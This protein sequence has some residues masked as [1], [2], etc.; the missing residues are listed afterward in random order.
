MDPSSDH[1]EYCTGGFD[2]EDIVISGMSGRFPESDSVR[3]LKEGL[4]NKK[5]FVVFTDKRFEKGAYHAPYDSSGL[6]KELDKLDIN[7]FHVAYAHAQQMDPASR[8]HLE[9]TYE[10]IADA[11]ID[12]TDLR[13]ARVGVFNATT[14]E[15]TVKINTSD[16]SFVSLNAI[17][18]MNPNRT[19]HSFDFTGPSYTIDAACSSSA[20]ALWSAV[21]TLRMGQID[22]AVVSGC[23]LNLH[24]CMLAG[25]IGAGIVSTTGNSRPFDAKSDGMIKTEAV[26]AIF[27]QKAKVAR[28]VYAIIP[29][30]RCYSAGYVPEGVNVPSDVMQK[31]IMLDTLNDANVDINDIDFIEAHGTGTQVGDKIELNAI[32][33]VFCKNRSKP[34]LVGAVKSNIGHTEASSGI[35]GVIKSIL[36]FE[37]ESI[38]PNIKFEVPNPN[39]PAL[40]DGKL[41]VVTEP[42]P[43]KKDYI[44]INSLGFG[45][46]L[47]QILLKKNP[48]APGGKK[49][50]SNIP[51]LILFPGTTEEAITTIFE[52]L[53]NTPNLPEEFFALLNKLSFTDPSLKPFRGY[54]LYQGGN[55]PIKEIRVRYSY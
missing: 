2:P 4:Y 31:R 5:D 41:V 19:T 33:E 14:G 46:T 48:I 6:I 27:L 11:G 47:V 1:H 15:D 28:R 44:P 45:G 25:Y 51:R 54:A 39:T 17:R 20:I 23:Q 26:T 24:P 29:A 43:F 53:Q 49:Q 8:I 35:C 32:A 37:Y 52:Y 38:P 9:V 34:L 12:A 3:E 36:A 21:N 22:A 55:C 10:A 50:E 30:I 16:E 42:T 18:T 7:F 13:G 40:L